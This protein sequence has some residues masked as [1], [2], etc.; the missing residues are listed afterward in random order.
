[1]LIYRV[2]NNEYAGMYRRGVAERWLNAA[3]ILDGCAS[4]E[5]HPPPFLDPD[6][7]DAWDMLTEQGDRARYIFGF[8]SVE[9][10]MKWVWHPASRRVLREQGFFLR[11]FEVEEGFYYSG[12]KQAIFHRDHAKL[13]DERAVDFLDQQ[14]QEANPRKVL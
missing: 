2:E 1:M 13:V 12:E 14:D 6:I 4:S 7:S 5:E 3:G 11:V 9:S 10:F 8:A